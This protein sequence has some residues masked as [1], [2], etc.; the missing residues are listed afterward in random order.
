M[1]DM[2][3]RDYLDFEAA[4]KYEVYK[5]SEPRSRVGNAVPVS[6]SKPINRA[7]AKAARKARKR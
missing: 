1:K 4:M 6:K 7:K 5:R 2:I 3:Q